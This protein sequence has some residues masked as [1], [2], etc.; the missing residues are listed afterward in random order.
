MKGLP[1]L[2]IIGVIALVGCANPV[3]YISSRTANS[4]SVVHYEAF[5]GDCEQVGADLAT[6]YCL[7]QGGTATVTG[8]H[9]DGMNGIITIDY[10]CEK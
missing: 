10:K 8:R 1:Q 6:N 9:V 5:C 3:P 4:V 7:S 2:T